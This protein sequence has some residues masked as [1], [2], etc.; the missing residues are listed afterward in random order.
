MNIDKEIK[1]LRMQLGLSPSE[2][3]QRADL[4]PAYISKL[5]KGEYKNFSLKTCKAL[6]N[7]FGMTLREFLEAISFIDKNENRPSSYL[8][9]EAFRSEGYTDEEIRR[10]REYGEFIRKD[11]KD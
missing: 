11:N 2:L 4:T 5:E 8:I 7:G 6:A 3:A 10:I 9:R 1:K